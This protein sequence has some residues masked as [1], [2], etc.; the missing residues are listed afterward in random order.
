MNL[1]CYVFFRFIYRYQLRTSCFLLIINEQR[2]KLIRK[3]CLDDNSRTVAMEMI[4]LDRGLS[5]LFV[6]IIYVEF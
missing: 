4:I 5:Y 3:D 6:F 2:D 1:C